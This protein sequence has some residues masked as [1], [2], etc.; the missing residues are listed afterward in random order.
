MMNK[1]LSHRK[2]IMPCLGAIIGYGNVAEVFIILTG[3]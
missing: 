3:N 1:V 2:E